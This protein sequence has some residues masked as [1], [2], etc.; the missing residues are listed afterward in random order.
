MPLGNGLFGVCRVLSKSRSSRNS[1]IVAVSSWIGE[2]APDVSDPRLREVYV[3]T[4]H[5]WG[6]NEWNCVTVSGPVPSSF[7]LLGT[8]EPAEGEGFRIGIW[9]QWEGLARH[10]VTQWR[11]DN[12]REALL[13]EEQ[14]ERERTERERADDATRHQNYLDS[15]TLESLRKKKRFAEWQGDRPS[16][17]IAACRKVFSALID[18]II[19]LGPKP[20]EQEVSAAVRDCVEK[21]NKLD[22]QFDGF[23]ETGEREALCTEI[24]EI[25]Y[26]SG[27]RNCDGMADEW[28]DW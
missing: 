7:R 16:K 24:D 1:V 19:A 13:K 22:E 26:A 15:L 5:G 20:A 2:E 17:A 12:D 28:R 6:P 11:W 10:L 18:A 21:L 25:V 3:E 9:T 23:T 14:E 8:I 4:H 27:L